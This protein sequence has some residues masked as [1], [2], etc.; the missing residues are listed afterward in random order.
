MKTSLIGLKKKDIRLQLHGYTLSECWHDKPIPQGLRIQKA[1]TIGKESQD[2]V[3]KWCDILN[4]C[5]MDLMLLIT[6][7]VTK[8]KEDALKDISNHEALKQV[9]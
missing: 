2:F 5:S 8:Q 4:K 7:E 9:K 1:P 6:E 3:K